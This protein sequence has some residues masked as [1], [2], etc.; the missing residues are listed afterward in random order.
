MYKGKK[1][2]R[3]KGKGSGWMSGTAHKMPEKKLLM[4]EV[5]GKTI[6]TYTDG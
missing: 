6:R 1:L 5:D 2:V 4:R 3:K